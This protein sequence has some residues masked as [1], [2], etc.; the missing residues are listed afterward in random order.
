M[1]V[2]SWL[3]FLIVLVYTLAI[4]SVKLEAGWGVVSPFLTSWLVDASIKP[5]TDSLLSGYL[6]DRRTV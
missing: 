3:R 2:P 1:T 5:T 6:K 4:H